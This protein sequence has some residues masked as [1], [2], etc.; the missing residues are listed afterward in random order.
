MKS[1]V[2]EKEYL[3]LSMIAYKNFHEEDEGQNILEALTDL[4]KE[5]I[6]STHFKV[7][8]N[9]GE[10]FFLKYFHRELKK[11]KILKLYKRDKNISLKNL[12]ESNGFYAI[13]FTDG[14]NVVIAFRG[15]ELYPFEEAIKDFVGND[16]AI[17]IGLRPKQFDD[18]KSFYMMHVKD[19]EIPKEKI[20]LTGH[21]LGGGL[22]QFV[23]VIADKKFGYV[24]FTCTWNA[25]GIRKE[26]I[27]T[28]F[29]LIDFKRI[30]SRGMVLSK[31]Q[32]EILSK[33]KEP[34]LTFLHEFK[35]KSGNNLLDAYKNNK[36]IIKLLH[37]CVEKIYQDH[38]N[39]QNH[40]HERSEIEQNL[41]QIF[42]NSHVEE[43]IKEAHK[44]LREFNENTKYSDR[45]INYG[46]SQDVT[47]T[48]Y[49]HIGSDIYLDLDSKRKIS[50]VEFLALIIRKEKSFFEFHFE[51]VFI[52]HI[53][54]D[55]K[56]Y[57]KIQKNLSLDFVA[58]ILRKIMHI[59]KSISNQILGNFYSLKKINKE[60]IFSHRAEIIYSIEK[61]KLV[62]IFRKRTVEFLKNCDDK[63][64]LEVWCKAKNKMESP[65]IQQDIYDVLVWAES[66]F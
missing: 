48:I 3:F 58:S 64:F 28:F 49:E 53:I 5:K 14:E 22:A 36:K 51:D 38:K 19:L 61:S 31:S 37:D 42:F 59:D 35:K 34:Y 44:T 47:N 1:Q 62:F 55:K 27:I 63:T 41:I 33:F 6:L 24:P 57:G 39:N 7:M 21:S 52:P 43:I 17:G 4:K 20:S 15:S 40:T 60:V 2:V 10:P 9:F 65:Y 50:T 30:I 54:E 12:T 26:G 11:W 29:D 25:I 13:S 18:A 46:H 45:V 66:K 32:L 8:T 56:E 16:L 23:A